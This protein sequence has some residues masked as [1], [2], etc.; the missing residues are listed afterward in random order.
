MTWRDHRPPEFQRYKQQRAR[1]GHGSILRS[2]MPLIGGK[3]I[4]D[5]QKENKQNPK[6]KMKKK[7]YIIYSQIYIDLI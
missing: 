5:I 3:V 1:V 4:S 7:Y 6:S 2:A